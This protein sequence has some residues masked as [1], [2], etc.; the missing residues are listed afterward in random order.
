MT[1]QCEPI[2]LTVTQGGVSRQLRATDQCKPAGHQRAATRDWELVLANGHFQL[3]ALSAHSSLKT[4]MRYALRVGSRRVASGS[5]SLVRTYKPGR[6]ILLPE[7][8]FLDYLRARS[9][10]RALVRQQGRLPDSGDARGAPRARL[11]PSGVRT[12]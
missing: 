7:K 8:G 11:R 3:H 6:L 9:L 2:S 1:S 5:L 12:H 10:R 4:R